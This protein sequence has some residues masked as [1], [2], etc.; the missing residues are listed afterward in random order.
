MIS[1]VPLPSIA[2][3]L[4]EAQAAGKFSFLRWQNV[5]GVK[6]AAFSFGVD[7]KKTHYTVSY[8]CFPDTDRAGTATFT[9]AALGGAKGSGGGGASGNLQTSTSYSKTFKSGTGYHGEIFI[10]P[11]SGTVL[12]LITQAELKSSDVVHQ[13][14]ILI[15]YGPA[16]VGGKMLIVPIK[17]ITHSEVVPNGDSGSGK[18]STRHTYLSAEYKDYH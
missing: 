13:E 3:V 11:E 12:R 14:E 8:C 9:S 15:D 7:K 2:S 17:T 16:K 5:N 10:D 1:T 6:A 18:Y 4:Q